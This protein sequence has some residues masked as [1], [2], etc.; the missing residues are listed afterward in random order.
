MFVL[1]RGDLGV[2]GRRSGGARARVPRK[3]KRAGAQGGEQEQGDQ[4]VVARQGAGQRVAL[5]GKKRG[6][7][8]SARGL[9]RRRRR[10]PSSSLLSRSHL[11]P[12]ESSL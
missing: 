4:A 11:S 12:R 8:G 3:G 1:Q 5:S 2:R 7:V 9:A 10:L 6:K